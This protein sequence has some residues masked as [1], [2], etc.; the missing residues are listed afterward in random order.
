MTRKGKH[1]HLYEGQKED[2]GNYRMVYLTSIPENAMEQIPMEGISRHVKNK[3]VIG[4]SQHE[5]SKCILFLPTRLLQQAAQRGGV[6]PPSLRIFK[7]GW[8]SPRTT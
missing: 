7:L 5:F 4:N 6:E 3:K 2:L 8:T 1:H